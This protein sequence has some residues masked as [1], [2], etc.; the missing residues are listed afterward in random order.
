MERLDVL[1]S[2]FAVDLLAYAVTSN[3]YHLLEAKNLALP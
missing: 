3:H 1:G 2:V